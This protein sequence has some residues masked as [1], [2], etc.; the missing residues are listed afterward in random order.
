MDDFIESVKDLVISTAELDFDEF[1]DKELNKLIISSIK[2]ITIIV[3]IEN[4]YN[5]EFEDECL[6]EG[7][8]QTYEQLAE[9]IQ[10]AINRT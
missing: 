3:A 4:K 2:Y 10:K 8:F 5:F 7:Y 6:L 9:Y 1:K